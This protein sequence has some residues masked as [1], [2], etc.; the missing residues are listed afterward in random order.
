MVNLIQMA[1]KNRIA[2][3]TQHFTH[4]I[5]IRLHV[6]N[7]VGKLVSELINSAIFCA[8]LISLNPKLR[9]VQG[10][11]RADPT[12]WPIISICTHIFSGMLGTLWLYLSDQGSRS[13]ILSKI[14]HQV[15]GRAQAFVT[16]SAGGLADKIS[17]KGFGQCLY[18]F[19]LII[20]VAE[21]YGFP[22]DLYWVRLQD[23]QSLFYAGPVGVA[24]VYVI[25][26]G[27][28]IY[29]EN[30]TILISESAGQRM[31]KLGISAGTIGHYHVVF[32]GPETVYKLQQVGIVYGIPV[33]AFQ[34]ESGDGT[35]SVSVHKP[36]KLVQ[37][38]ILL[39]K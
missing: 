21:H 6:I 13:V 18:L 38:Q 14:F 8:P 22:G 34:Q 3:F 33:I 5:W 4:N 7:P 20:V 23:L 31:P 36:G 32:V 39:G 24:A 28:A 26:F 19:Q 17:T 30:D 9:F 25:V 16:K 1:R 10:K 12:A 37:I 29:A 11:G 35:P 2:R 27:Q 15:L